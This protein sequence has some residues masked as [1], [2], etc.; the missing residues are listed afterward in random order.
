[1][2]VPK[3][4]LW[5]SEV[6]NKETAD[7][8]S[9][10]ATLFTSLKFEYLNIRIIFHCITVA[11]WEYLFNRKFVF[12]SLNF[13]G[14]FLSRKILCLQK[15]TGSLMAYDICYFVFFSL[16]KSTFEARKNIFYFTPKA[17]SVLET[18]KFQ[19]FGLIFQILNFSMSSNELVWKK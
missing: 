13:W 16:R 19:N 14:F 18:L 10:H 9:S 11:S 15:M 17:L 1:M 2:A 5:G 8:K 6:L 4:W 12:S 3:S 7:S